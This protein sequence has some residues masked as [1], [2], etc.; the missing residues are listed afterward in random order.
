MSKGYL[1]AVHELFGVV[2]WRL[3][4][5]AGHQSILEEDHPHFLPVGV[6]HGG[7]EGDE[8][9]VGLEGQQLLVHA[10]VEH[11]H[12]VVGEVGRYSRYP[13]D[14]SVEPVV[15]EV[16]PGGLGVDVQLVLGVHDAH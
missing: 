5:E 9:E 11:G 14:G 2:D 4:V 10:A 12:V 1:D 7:V 16:V 8:L 13:V 3:V 6:V 15:D